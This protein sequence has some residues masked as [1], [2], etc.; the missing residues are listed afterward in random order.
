MSGNSNKSGIESMLASMIDSVIGEA[1][2]EGLD[3]LANE[4]GLPDGEEMSE[5]LKELLRLGGQLGELSGQLGAMARRHSTEKMKTG[6][7]D[8]VDQLAS[9]VQIIA[10]CCLME[11]KALLMLEYMMVAGCGFLG[12]AKLSHR[13]A[14]ELIMRVRLEG[15]SSHREIFAPGLRKA[16]EFLEHPEVLQREAER[17][18]RERRG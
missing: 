6:L 8:I 1:R 18:R 16:L 5:D 14:G 12:T 17:I 2:E 10:S 15:E 9:H 11:P 13:E 7:H 3:E 4:S